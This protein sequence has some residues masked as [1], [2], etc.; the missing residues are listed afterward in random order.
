[1]KYKCNSIQECEDCT[2]CFHSTEHDP[3]NINGEMCT[4]K[5]VCVVEG[6]SRQVQC[7]ELS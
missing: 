6:V 3:V 4:A 5:G 1:M 2:D 7:I